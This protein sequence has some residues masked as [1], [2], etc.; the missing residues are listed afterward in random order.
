MAALDGLPDKI[1][2]LR[3]KQYGDK[4]AE[5]KVIEKRVENVR[6]V[7]SMLDSRHHAAIAACDSLGLAAW[8]P[9]APQCLFSL[10]LQPVADHAP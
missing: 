6:V 3:M 9:S 7:N 8:S 1:Y 2:E 5:Q 4:T 10:L